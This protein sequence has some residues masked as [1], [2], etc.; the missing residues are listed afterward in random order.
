VLQETVGLAAALWAAQRSLNQGVTP[1]VIQSVTS[2]TD[3]RMLGN[4]LSH[5]WD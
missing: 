3:V 2:K 5:R 1:R 4:T